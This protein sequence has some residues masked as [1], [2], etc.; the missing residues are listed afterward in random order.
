MQNERQTSGAFWL[1]G[2]SQRDTEANGK[3]GRGADEAD[4]GGART[5]N[6]PS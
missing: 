5:G 2:R 4:G 6:C 1:K 3:E